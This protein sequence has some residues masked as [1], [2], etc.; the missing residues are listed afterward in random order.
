MPL[1]SQPSPGHLV[2]EEVRGSAGIPP[3]PADMTVNG[4]FG[5][6]AVVLSVS[7]GLTWVCCCR[8]CTSV[9]SWSVGKHK[10]SLSPPTTRPQT[11][12][13][14]CSTT[15]PQVS[16]V[17]HAK[18]FTGQLRP[19]FFVCWCQIDPAASQGRQGCCCELST[20]NLLDDKCF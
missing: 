15:G 19:N 11:S 17:Q 2:S 5:V 14:M 1:P 20:V 6:C 4:G 13:S 9:S 3:G 12:P 18:I 7:A 10:T 8:R 16:A